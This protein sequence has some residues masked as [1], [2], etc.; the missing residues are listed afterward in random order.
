MNQAA[1]TS[2]LLRGPRTACADRPSG[3][4]IRHI[5]V[6]SLYV[7]FTG[8]LDIDLEKSNHCTSYRDGAAT[9]AQ[10]LRRIESADR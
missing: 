3:W 6:G 4:R 9:C 10:T 8:A 1:E 2:R 7:D 5:T